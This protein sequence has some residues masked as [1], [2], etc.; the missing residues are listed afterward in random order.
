MAVKR[1][2]RFHE[3]VTRTGSVFH[4]LLIDLGQLISRKELQQTVNQPARGYRSGMPL[5]ETALSARSDPENLGEVIGPYHSVVTETVARFEGFVAKYNGQRG[6]VN[7]GYPQTHEEDA[8][9]ALC[10]GPVVVDE[11]GGC[12]ARH[13][14]AQRSQ[15]AL[16]GCSP[17]KIPIPA[18]SAVI[19]RPSHQP[20]E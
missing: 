1:D 7:F 6:L 10:A 5:R 18:S 4:P 13:R 8:E 15:I 3:G 2:N 19:H 14:I 17:A 16:V 9:R 11:V 20:A 12:S